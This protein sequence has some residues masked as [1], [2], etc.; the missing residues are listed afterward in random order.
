MRLI[1]V[2]AAITGVCL[3]AG[4]C[5]TQP[6][7]GGDTNVLGLVFDAGGSAGDSR[8]ANNITNPT[9]SPIENDNVVLNGS[10][11]GRGN[12]QMFDLG[13]GGVGDQWTV[14][15]ANVAFLSRS[16]T[17]VLFDE[18]YNLLMRAPVTNTAGLGHV[19]RRDTARVY[20]GIMPAFNSTG[21][22]FKLAVR[23][24]PNALVPA[25]QPQTVWLNFGDGG[26]V[27]VHGRGG[28][29]FAPFDA[30]LLGEAYVGQTRTIKD[31]IVETIR[32]DYA[33]YNVTIHTSDEGPPPAG[34][35]STVHFGGFDAGLLGLADEVDQYNQNPSQ[36]AIIY[37]DTF[38]DFASMQL[39]PTE[40]G[41]MIGNVGSHE[42]GHLLGLYHTRNPTDVMDTTGSAWQL[43][44]AQ[45]FS[46]VELEQTVFPVGLENSPRRLE[47]TVGLAPE[48]LAA[49]KPPADAAKMKRRLL[50]RA[51][52][53][54]EVRSGCGTCLELDAPL[55]GGAP[56]E[57]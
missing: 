12:Y 9:P 28:I 15:L 3:L 55:P 6:S 20:L 21:G 50:W 40:M 43:A 57:P 31:T 25:P 22:D 54:E 56:D 8:G 14:S 39:T 42:L 41:L 23:R 24:A 35:Y 47:E 13:A 7:S 29:N 36:N 4:G 27:R 19:L 52:A 26:D 37:V 49:S 18:N 53:A 33:P 11:S 46:R 34:A 10:V 38:A 16:F 5:P 51:W 30:A 17:V 2:S 32:E 48:T 1:F 44:G 45:R